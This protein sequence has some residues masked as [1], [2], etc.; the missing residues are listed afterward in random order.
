MRQVIGEPKN[1]YSSLPEYLTAHKLGKLIGVDA[2]RM[3]FL[4]AEIFLTEGLKHTLI[5][6]HGEKSSKVVYETNNGLEFKVVYWD[7]RVLSKC[8]S[9]GIYSWRI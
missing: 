4:L 8:Y 3:N 5:T 1:G 9:H 7:V 6:P 2:K